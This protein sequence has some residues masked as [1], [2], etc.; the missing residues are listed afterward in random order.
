[1]IRKYDK[2]DT[3]TA[4]VAADIINMSEGTARRW[5][6]KIRVAKNYK[7]YFP[8]SVGEFCEYYHRSL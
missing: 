7:P 1:M 5:L 3:C 2:N 4:S 8:I 6:Q